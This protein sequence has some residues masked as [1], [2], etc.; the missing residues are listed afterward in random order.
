MIMVLFLLHLA[1][2]DAI[3]KRKTE[4]PEFYAGGKACS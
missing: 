3:L 2:L 4:P 1:V